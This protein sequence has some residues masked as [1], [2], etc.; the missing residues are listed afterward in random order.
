MQVLPEKLEERLLWK[1]LE[2]ILAKNS[3]PLLEGQNTF[4]LTSDA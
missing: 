3:L 2:T 4:S 1:L